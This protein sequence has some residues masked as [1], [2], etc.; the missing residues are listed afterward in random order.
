MRSE[1][2]RL[3]AAAGLTGLILALASCSSSRSF[4]VLHLKSE[5]EGV[6]FANIQ[7]VVVTVSQ[8]TSLSKTLTYPANGL[9]IDFV[10]DNDLS[11]NFTAEQSGAVTIEAAAIDGNGCTVARA[12]TTAVI[13]MGAT[14]HSTAHFFAYNSCAPAD[15]GVPRADGAVFPGCDPAV[16]APACGAGKT[17]QVKCSATP[18]VNECIPSG[19]GKHGAACTTNMDC[20]PGT[21]CFKYASPGCAVSVCLRYCAGEAQCDPSTPDGG[22]GTRSLCAGPVQCDSLLTAYRTCSFG[23]DPRESALAAQA[24]RCPAGLSCLVVGNMDQVDC[25]CPE[26]SRVGT[27]GADCT[28]GAQCAPGFICN[29]MGGAKKCRALCRCDARNGACTAPNDCR[30]AGKACSVLTNDTLFGVCL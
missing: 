11:I 1:R 29:L 22:V 12:A 17:C 18:K 21:Q 7:E 15:G 19:T 20:E 13:R 10:T 8:G 16:P 2:A 26:P 30:A 23:C 9:T 3:I 27:D 24:T 25:A 28:G 4:V 14:A 5:A 6:A